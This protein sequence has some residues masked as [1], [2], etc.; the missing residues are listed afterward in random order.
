MKHFLFIALFNH[1][2]S[3][4]NKLWDCSHSTA[5]KRLRAEKQLAQ[6]HRTGK[7]FNLDSLSLEPTSV[8]E[9]YCFLYN[10]AL[11]FIVYLSEQKSVRVYPTAN[12]DD[13]RRLGP[14]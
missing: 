11:I 9:Q 2:A 3:T 14:E 4:P 1:E 13:L 8:A 10:A 5:G 7:L 6:G 12:S